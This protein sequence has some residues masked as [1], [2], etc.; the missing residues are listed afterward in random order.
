[1]EDWSKH[2]LGFRYSML[3]CLKQD[4]EYYLS[5]GNGNPEHLWAGDERSQIE[6]MAAIWKSFERDERPEW[7][8]WGDIVYYAI[9]MG[10]RFYT[11]LNYTMYFRKNREE[12]EE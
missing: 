8:S 7:F 4:C 1:M 5:Y 12:D 6:N 2:G 10:V 9:K 11:G 3:G